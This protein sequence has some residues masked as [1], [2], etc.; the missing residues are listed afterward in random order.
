VGGQHQGWTFGSG[1]DKTQERVLTH[2][3]TAIVGGDVSMSIS[4]EVDIPLIAKVS[5][6]FT[7]GA[8]W[9]SQSMQSTSNRDTNTLKMSITHS[10]TTDGPLEPQHAIHCT[11]D[12]FTSTYN[13]KFTATVRITMSNGNSYDIKQPGKLVSVLYTKMIEDCN[14]QAINAVPEDAKCLQDAVNH[15]NIYGSGSSTSAPAVPATSA[16]SKRGIAFQG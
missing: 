9:E 5:S 7:V 1:E 3:N 12:T 4:A 16:I 2:Q 13:S 6:S 10:S 15:W 14:T 11:V 8:H